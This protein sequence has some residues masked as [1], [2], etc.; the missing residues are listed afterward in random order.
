M[1][2][3]V[4]ALAGARVAEFAGDVGAALEAEAEVIAAVQLTG[5][6]GG[7]FLEQF[8]GFGGGKHHSGR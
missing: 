8:V 4:P 5:W 3:V 1:L 6:G 7:E 2:L